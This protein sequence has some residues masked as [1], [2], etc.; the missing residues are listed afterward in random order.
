[1]SRTESLLVLE[2][3]TTAGSVALF[4]DGRLVSRQSVAMGVSREDMLY[5][6]V[7]Q[8]LETA[9]VRAAYLAGIVC[10]AGPGSFTSLRIAASMAKGLAYSI[11][12][13]L[14]GVSSLLLAAAQCEVPGA[15][16]VHA[17]ALRDERYVLP[18]FIDADGLVHADGVAHRAGVDELRQTQGERRRLAVLSSPD[19]EREWR[20]VCPDAALALRC[21]DWRAAGPL[22]LDDWEP[23]YGRL[24]EAQV[25]WEVVNGRTLRDA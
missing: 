16:L 10:G 2:A 17:D 11:G 22:S 21:A 18:V 7:E 1:M 24:A 8:L 25:K 20:T 12:C 14:Y 5:P 23:N 6:A 13:P 3:A 15:Y 4:V 9:N 19:P